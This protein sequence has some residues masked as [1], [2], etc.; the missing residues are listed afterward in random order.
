MA[1][2]N[3]SSMLNESIQ[4]RKQDTP[5]PENVPEEVK[6][7]SV[8]AAEEAPKTEEPKL[9][10]PEPEEAAKD[11]PSALPAQEDSKKELLRAGIVINGR[12]GVERQQ[13]SV[14]FERDV[15]DRVEQLAKDNHLSFSAV[16]NQILRQ[17]L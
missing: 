13:R 3:F 11:L 2:K 16:I 6:E 10:M 7:Q 8:P 9:P 4:G 17:V 1:R 12:I 5:K 14:N 15:L